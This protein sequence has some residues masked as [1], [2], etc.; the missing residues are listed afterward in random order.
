[1]P[2]VAMVSGSSSSAKKLMMIGPAM[3]ISSKRPMST[4]MDLV[5]NATAISRFIT[6]V[7]VRMGE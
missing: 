2:T 1:M 5:L 3:A 4:S 7:M 6:V